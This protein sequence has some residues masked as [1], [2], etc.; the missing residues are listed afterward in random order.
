MQDNISI[1]GDLPIGKLCVPGSHNSGMSISQSETFF[2]ISSATQT[3][4]L[5]IE[6]QLYLGIRYFDVRPCLLSGKFYTGHY[7]NLPV[8]G[9]Q[10]ANG[11]SIDSIIETLNRYTSRHSELI[12][13]NLSHAFNINTRNFTNLNQE[14]WNLLFE[15][16]QH[17]VEN[18]FVAPKDVDLSTLRLSDYIGKNKSAV[19]FVVDTSESK[20]DIDLEE[21]I[22]KG[23]Y[24]VKSLNLFDRYSETN[25]LV[26]MAKDQVNKMIINGNSYFLLSWTLT[27]NTFD[28]LISVFNR[29]FL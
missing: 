16:L 6:E 18:M 5:P 19:V 11:E 24:P 1:I 22:G 9:W 14:E 12:I 20:E 29:F 25:D 23:I 17:Y 4:I 28:V 26:K 27:Q 15:T 8:I 21:Y 7:S 2:S 13:F 10:G 3:Q